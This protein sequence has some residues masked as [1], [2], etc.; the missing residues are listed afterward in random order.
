MSHC[1]SSM[2]FLLKKVRFTRANRAKKEGRNKNVSMGDDGYFLRP[3]RK[4]KRLWLWKSMLD[5]DFTSNDISI[6][7]LMFLFDLSKVESLK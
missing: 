2:V 6:Y 4:K 7:I 5:G 1:V 3:L